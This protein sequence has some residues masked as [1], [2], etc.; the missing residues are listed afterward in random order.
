M[1]N[2]PEPKSPPSVYSTT[3]VRDT[4]ASTSRTACSSVVGTP[5]MPRRSGG[6]PVRLARTACS[7]FIF[8]PSPVAVVISGRVPSRA[9]YGGARARRLPDVEMALAVDGHERLEP[10]APHVLE[11]PHQ[12]AGLV[13]V[14][15]RVDAPVFRR[16]LVQQPPERHIDLGID[17]DNGAPGAGGRRA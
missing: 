1:T 8:V 6:M 4:A 15:D 14:A 7:M 5:C 9:E 17:R 13:A 2:T 10:H 3:P 12:H 16:C 11:R